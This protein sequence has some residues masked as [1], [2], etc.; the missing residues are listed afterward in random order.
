MHQLSAA[1]QQTNRAA[2]GGAMGTGYTED[3]VSVAT[4]AEKPL[5]DDVTT[6]PAGLKTGVLDLS[7]GGPFGSAG[8]LGRGG[9]FGSG[10]LLYRSGLPIKRP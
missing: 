8:A 5:L 4:G 10:T 9:S 7:G 3:A 6:S 2:G 1:L